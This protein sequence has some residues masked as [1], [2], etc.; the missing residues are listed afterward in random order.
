MT[1][2]MEVILSYLKNK[3]KGRLLAKRSSIRLLIFIKRNKKKIKLK[4]NN[5]GLTNTKIKKSM[6]RKSIKKKMKNKSLRNTS[7]KNQKKFNKKNSIKMMIKK[8]S[9]N[10]KW[11]IAKSR[12][13]KSRKKKKEKLK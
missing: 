9:R 12:T 4:K 6:K 10:N 11:R 7:K 5:K 3:I 2:L 8:N 13:W 1:K